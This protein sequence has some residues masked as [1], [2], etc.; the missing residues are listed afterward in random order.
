MGLRLGKR[1]RALVTTTPR[2]TRLIKQLVADPHTVL[3]KGTTFENSGNLPPAFLGAI[4]DKYKGT[5]LGRQE[6]EAEILLDTP[7]A[8]WTIESI[9]RTRIAPDKAPPLRRIVVALDPAMATSDGACETGLI[10]AG[11]GQLDSRGY[12]LHDASGKY[13]PDGWARQAVSLFDQYQADRIVSEANLPCGEIVTNTLASIRASLPLKLIHTHSG[14]RVRAEPVAAL[15]E[16]GKV[17]HCGLFDALEDQLTGWDAATSN[18]SPDRLD[19]LVHGLT[20]LMLNEQ[21]GR[22]FSEELIAQ[23]FQEAPKPAAP[24][25]PKQISRP[26]WRA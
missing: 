8:L 4:L 16:Q 5:R 3:V 24:P 2:P 13:T 7:G 12:L 23:H 21:P 15:Y 1:P 6:L 11:I 18:E 17:S 25:Q 19:A 22:V 9:E 26:F 10:V 20:E 14:K